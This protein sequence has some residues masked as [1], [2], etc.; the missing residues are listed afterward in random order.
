MRKY[1]SLQTGKEK[2]QKTETN[3]FQKGR[4]SQFSKVKT[5]LFSMA[6]SKT[7]LAPEINTSRRSIIGTRAQK[8]LRFSG[9]FRESKLKLSSINMK[10]KMYN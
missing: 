1:W 7:L 8:I 2:E 10:K 4:T 3:I 9:H 5:R 6:L